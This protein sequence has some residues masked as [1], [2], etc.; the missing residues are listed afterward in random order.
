MGAG[1][2]K[3][4]RGKAVAA[5]AQA[6]YNKFAW[7][8]F[9]NDNGIAKVGVAKYYLGHDVQGPSEAE[10]N[11]VLCEIFADLVSVG[12]IVLP[13]PYKAE[14]FKFKLAP[15]INRNASRYPI[16]IY[17]KNRLQIGA[18]IISGVT[19][20]NVPLSSVPINLLFIQIQHGITMVFI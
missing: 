17:L 4:R 7:D 20:L 15:P 1:T 5:Q 8:E 12:A 6:T 19:D 16:D 13:S 11:K 2:G 18:N 14:D 10:Y 3:T 9:L